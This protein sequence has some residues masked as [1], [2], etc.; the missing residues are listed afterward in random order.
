LGAFLYTIQIYSDFS[1]YSDMAIGIA[2]LLGFNITKNFDFP[3]FSQ[4]IAEYWRK[5]HMSL[6]SWMTDYVFTPL[7]ITFRDYGKFGLILSILIN[8]TIIGI[9][10]GP[11]WTYALFGILHGCYYIP[12]ILRGTLNKRKKIAKEKLLP[13]LRE[14]INMLSTFILVMLTLIVFKSNTIGQAYHYF[15][16]LFSLSVFSKPATHIVFN[17]EI[18]YFIFFMFLLE[19]LQRDK[20]H[21]LQFSQGSIYKSCSIV[22][23]NC[24]IIWAIILWGAYGNKEFIYFQF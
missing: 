15:A 10:H 7:S 14:F 24:F 17:V 16:N 20:E 2:R 1:G 22:L 18:L 11:N 9:W 3:F 5:W 12:L 8:F 19:W 4:N 13:S 23:L 21:A 6:T